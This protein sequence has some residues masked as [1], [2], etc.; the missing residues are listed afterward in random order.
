M[1]IEGLEGKY[2]PLLP[3]SSSS[4][5]MPCSAY[6]GGGHRVEI[7]DRG[8]DSDDSLRDVLHHGQG[9]VGFC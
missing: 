5:A 7:F 8:D 9:T 2:L 4:L 1:W 3:P 6:Y